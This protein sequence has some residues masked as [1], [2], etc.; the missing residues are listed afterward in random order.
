MTN[1]GK[2][3]FRQKSRENKS[4]QNRGSEVSQS[5]G[6]WENIMGQVCL[7]HS[8]SGAESM[9]HGPGEEIWHHLK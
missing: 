3:N 6:S 1:K 4:V 7:H 8:A 9:A 5:E 2:G